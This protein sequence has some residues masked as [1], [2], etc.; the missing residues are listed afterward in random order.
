MIDFII[1]FQ[2]KDRFHHF[3]T[4][5]TLPRPFCPPRRRSVSV[6]R[7][8][9][10]AKGFWKALLNRF[11]DDYVPSAFSGY[12]LLQRKAQYACCGKKSRWN[13]NA[14]CWR[15]KRRRRQSVKND[16][17]RQIVCS[18][19][20]HFSKMVRDAGLEPAN[21]SVLGPKPSAFANFASRA[22]G[23]RL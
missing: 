11:H 8:G 18:T 22:R 23:D 6:R 20:S 1:F 15:W 2:K 9:R 7:R 12:C 3:S 13:S 14:S 5:R 19:G 17:P 16:N 10:L 21:L 4:H